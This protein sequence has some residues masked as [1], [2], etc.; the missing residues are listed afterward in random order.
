MI[1]CRSSRHIQTKLVSQKCKNLKRI[2]FTSS[3]SIA[4]NFYIKFFTHFPSLQIINLQGTILDNESFDSIGETCHQL[5]ELNVSGSTI[6]D[7]GLQY[8]SYNLSDSGALR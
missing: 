5:K 1:T 3:K 7:T 6:T 8:L 2:D 4:P